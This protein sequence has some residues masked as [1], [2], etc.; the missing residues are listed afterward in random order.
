LW[1]AILDKTS[2]IVSED[3]SHLSFAG[4]T[5]ESLMTENKYIF[6]GKRN[7]EDLV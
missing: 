1:Q 2:R 4:I 3:S 6:A 7:T 5:L